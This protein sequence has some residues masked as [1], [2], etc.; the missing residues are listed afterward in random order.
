MIRRYI[1][2]H[3]STPSSVGELSLLGWKKDEGKEVFFGPL[4]GLRFLYFV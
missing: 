2:T 3:F 1:C 4:K